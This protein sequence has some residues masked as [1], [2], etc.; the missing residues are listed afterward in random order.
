MY[1]MYSLI[2]YYLVR[3]IVLKYASPTH[4]SSS[5]SG[6]A[7]LHELA[8]CE[9]PSEVKPSPGE[10]VPK[11]SPQKRRASEAVAAADQNVT[12]KRRSSRVCT[13]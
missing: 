11:S 3:P 4:P 12:P 13:L 1:Y 5:I 10:A 8:V 6:M 2:C 9:S 7:L